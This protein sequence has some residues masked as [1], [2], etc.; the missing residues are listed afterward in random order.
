MGL[1]GRDWFHDWDR[2]V[3]QGSIETDRAAA[4]KR[5]A[6]FTLRTEKHRPKT[7]GRR[8]LAA[9]ASHRTAKAASRNQ[10]LSFK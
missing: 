1:G 9:L 4:G 8:A 7:S 6:I 3:E 2:V 10:Q 5:F